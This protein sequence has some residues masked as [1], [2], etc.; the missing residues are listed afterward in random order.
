MTAGN[1][2]E[3]LS[4]FVSTEFSHKLNGATLDPDFDLLS[5]GVIDSMGVM[6]L[7]TFIEE[8]F[9]VTVQ[10]EDIT[11]DNFRSINSLAGLIDTKSGGKA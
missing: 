2:R 4:G 8:S 5:E 9:G 10:D 7:V 11:P 6:Q 1:P 3:Q